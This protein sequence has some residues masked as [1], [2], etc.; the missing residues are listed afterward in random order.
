MSMTVQSYSNPSAPRRSRKDA[1]ESRCK[2]LDVA[3]KL[4]GDCG[5]E[6]VSMHQIAKTARVGQGTLY[7]NYAHKGELCLDLLKGSAEAFLHETKDWISDAQE[8]TD[9]L[10]VLEEVIVRVVDF[11]DSKAHLLAAINSTGFIGDNIFF[12]QLHDMVYA[13]VERVITRSHSPVDPTLATD[14]LLSAVGPS[15]YMFEREQRGYSKEQF[16][17]AIRQVYL[18]GLIGSNLAP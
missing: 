17:E 2:I 18:T 8:H 4:F 11:T 10:C 16:V 6:R 13:L 7:R 1:T 5:V 3:K 14:L 12:R 9:D 15:M